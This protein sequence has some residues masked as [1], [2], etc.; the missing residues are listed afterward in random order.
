VEEGA[1]P[2]DHHT[3]GRSPHRLLYWQRLRAALRLF[4]GDTSCA[5]W[6]RSNGDASCTL[7][8]ERVGGNAS[9]ATV[10]LKI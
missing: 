7:V 2:G 10:T 1:F 9:C 6:L 3:M 5:T 4:G 8:R